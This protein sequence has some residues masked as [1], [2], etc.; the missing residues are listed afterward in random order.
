MCKAESQREFAA[1]PM[2]LKQG[3]CIS[4]ERRG[5]EEMGGRF[6]RQGTLMAQ[7]VKNPPACSVGDPG[8]IP[9]LGRSRGE[10]KGYP[11]Q[12]SGLQNSMHCI[13]H[14]VTKSRTRL[15]DFSFR[16]ADSY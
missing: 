14:G 12:R 11:L 10:G 3:L 16:M 15:S 6:K 2:K 8:W 9:G 7:L 4:L 1:W 5:G 13:V